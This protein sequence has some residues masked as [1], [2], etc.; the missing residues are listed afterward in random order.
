VR[1]LAR[2]AAAGLAALAAAAGAAQADEALWARLKEGG[3]IV[4]I[5]H[6]STEAGVGDPPD[7]RLGEC[8]TQRNL[9]PTGR[10]ESMR[11][12]EVFRARGVSARQVLSSEWCRCRDTAAL[13][14]GDYAAWS[15]LNSFFGDRSTESAQTR[16]VRER[17]AGWKGPGNLVLVTH[18]VNITALTGIFLAPGEMVILRPGGDE[19]LELIGRIAP[20]RAGN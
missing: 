17:A 3:H 2:T 1:V 9:S 4:V 20:E 7:F 16:A 8:A 6:A 11:L 12:G 13:A 15:P 10:L 18:Q 14:C 5:R 19:R